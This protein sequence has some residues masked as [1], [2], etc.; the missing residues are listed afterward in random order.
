MNGTQNNENSSTKTYVDR[1][2]SSHVWRFRQKTKEAIEVE[3]QINNLGF[4][5]CGTFFRHLLKTREALVADM[6]EQAKTK[7][8]P[9][10]KLAESEIGF[11][12]VKY[13]FSKHGLVVIEKELWDKWKR[14]R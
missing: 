8:L 9:V 7:C 10:L 1:S 4:D 11:N 13:E 12:A 5:G 6:A 3:Q 14:K 2:K